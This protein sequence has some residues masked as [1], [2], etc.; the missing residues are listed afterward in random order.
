MPGLQRACA[1]WMVEMPVL[2]GGVYVPRQRVFFA[3]FAYA[4]CLQEYHAKRNNTCRKQVH[5]IASEL[6]GPLPYEQLQLHMIERAEGQ[7]ARQ[8]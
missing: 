2:S 4:P 3:S 8:K 1:R 7:T 6:D 5:R